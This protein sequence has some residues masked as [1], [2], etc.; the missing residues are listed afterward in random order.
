M[1][2]ITVFLLPL[3]LPALA[4][5]SV[6]RPQPATLPVPLPAGYVEQMAPA[7]AAPLLGQWWK[8]FADP[9][10]NALMQDAFA[11]NLDLAQGYAR[12][13]QA[14]AVLGATGA[15]E[16][17]TLDLS[18]NGGRRRQTAFGGTAVTDNSFSFSAPAA[19]EI[20]LWR[21]LANR[22]DAAR[23][24]A[25][26]SRDQLRSLYLTLS[27]RVADLYFLAVEQR[28]QLLLAD[29]NIAAFAD[30]LERVERR[31]RAG[32]VPALDLYQSRQN[33]A[34][35]RARR[36]QFENTLAGTEHALA[37]L[38]GRY[39]DRQSA[40]ERATLPQAV[41]EFP[42]GLPSQL[43]ARRP[44]IEANLQRLRASDARIAAAVAERFPALRL[45]GA[46]GGGSAVLGD[47][48]ASGN[49]FWN[50]LLNVAQPLYD[51]GRRRAEVE[52]TR[53]VFEENLALYHQSVLTA[54]REVED[55]LVAGLTGSE[56]I[57][58]LRERVTASESALRLALDR[59][60]QGLS[61]Y[62]PVLTAQGLNFEAQSQLLAA[63]RQLISDRI[64]LA[65]A[66]GGEWM[67][68]EVA[69]KASTDRSDR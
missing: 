36:P 22:T 29:A 21:K 46:A 32:L 26:A 65:R 15:A 59:Y 37:V 40:G 19:F 16:R 2:R 20:D 62:L 43:L 63:R 34:S 48:L 47:L 27:A 24:E 17:P 45:T 41:P 56:R 67:N 69:Q 50:L 23:L 52:R 14:Q 9:R 42:A 61:D 8:A 25:A 55:A 33:L 11:G 30:T 66:L 1:R 60:L 28:E 53:A 49:L 58:Q 4:G 64:S 6:H 12:L 51:G 54:F 18:G 68:A 31:Y 35:A 39:P 38:V 5:C 44:D 13:A 7:A 10:L 3:L 57:A